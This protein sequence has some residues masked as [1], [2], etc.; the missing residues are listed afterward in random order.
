VGSI[1]DGPDTDVAA[2]LAEQRAAILGLLRDV[3][4]GTASL[5]TEGTF[6][7]SDSQRTY[8]ARLTELRESLERAWRLLDAAVD[9]VERARARLPSV[10]GAD[11]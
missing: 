6:W 3:E 11:G 10:G 1:F 8:A 5:P 9:A 4:V 2:R 7:R